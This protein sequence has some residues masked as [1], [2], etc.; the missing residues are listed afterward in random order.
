MNAEKCSGTGN[1]C[2]GTGNVCRDCDCAKLWARCDRNNGWLTALGVTMTI[3][4]IMVFSKR[5]ISMNQMD[6][7]GARWCYLEES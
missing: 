7:A 1:V 6:Y 2:S 5:I 4:M 3:Q